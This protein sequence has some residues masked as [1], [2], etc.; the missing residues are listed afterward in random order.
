MP[1]APFVF[2]LPA[3]EPAHTVARVHIRRL[4]DALQLALA[5][6]DAPRARRAWAVLARCGEARWAGRWRTPLALLPDADAGRLLDMLL[7]TPTGEVCPPRALSFPYTHA[8]RA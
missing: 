3:A 7:Q 5:R 4:H 1:P 8:D 2:A 6:G